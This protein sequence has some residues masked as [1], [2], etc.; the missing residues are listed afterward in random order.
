MNHNLH[1]DALRIPVEWEIK[2]I[3]SDHG[4]DDPESDASWESLMRFCIETN[5]NHMDPGVVMSFL[6]Y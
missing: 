3:L 2:K 5:Q 1:P 4:G 6:G